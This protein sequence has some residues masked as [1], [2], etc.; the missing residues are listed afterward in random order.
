MARG[1]RNITGA[2]WC[3][4]LSQALWL[5]LTARSSWSDDVCRHTTMITSR[6]ANYFGDLSSR[7]IVLAERCHEVYSPFVYS[8]FVLGQSA[9]LS[10]IQT[11]KR[12]KRTLFIRTRQ[13]QQIFGVIPKSCFRTLA[14][15]LVWDFCC[16]PG[17]KVN[18]VLNVHRNHMAY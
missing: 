13:N 17:L 18:L 5:R 10:R 6:W 9:I 12:F 11:H 2:V 15:I 7:Q 16:L 14:V 4:C 3:H 8:A 1:V